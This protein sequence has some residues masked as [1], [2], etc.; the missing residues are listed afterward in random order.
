MWPT[1]YPRTPHWPWSATIHA[2][3]RV[4]QSPERFVGRDVVVT[5]KLDGSLVCLH[6][7]DVFLRSM[8]APSSAPWLAMVRKHHAWKLAA[9]PDLAI[10][11]EDLYGIHSIEYAP[12]AEADTFRVFGVRARIGGRD[13]FVDWEGV[14]AAAAQRDLP[15]VPVV[16]RGSFPSVD[17]VTAFFE[18]EIQR[19]SRVG[20]P[21]C[22][23]FVLRD[24]DAFEAD[25]FSR[26]VVKYVRPN[27]VQTDRHWTRHWRRAA[28]RPA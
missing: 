17:A 15:V 2:D 19:P 26:A 27:H 16:F 10:Y 20:G 21:D 18:S 9:A 6:R 13:R 4:H 22:E 24:A 7:G 12:M 14:E 23:G 1:K 25:Q 8:D 3:D 28:L 11:G 5:E